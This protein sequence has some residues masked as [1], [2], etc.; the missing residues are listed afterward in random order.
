MNKR[1]KF[2]VL[3][4]I[5]VIIL[6]LFY[7]PIDKTIHGFIIDYETATV[8]RVIDG[9]TLVADGRTI[10]LLGINTPERGEWYYNEAKEFLSNQTLE[11]EIK[12]FFG[13]EKKDKYG[14]TLAYVFIGS[15]NINQKIIEE[16]YANYYFPSGK[17]KYYDDFIESWEICLDKETNLCQNSEF[18]KCIRLNYFDY[19]TG[20]IILNNNC[21]DEINLNKWVVKSEGRKYFEIKN[22]S[23]KP[24]EEK[25]IYLDEN[26]FFEKRD[27]IFLKD[28]FNKIVSWTEG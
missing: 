12:L 24:Q 22:L 9:D 11:K 3:L 13:K 23:I 19:K 4:L 21:S 25:I 7:F 26:I 16:G 20:K 15:N 1:D 10:R 27:S 2:I 8:E 18:S 5:L 28:D 6:I 14:R 17:D